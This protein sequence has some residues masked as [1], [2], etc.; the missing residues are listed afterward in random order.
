[1]PEIDVFLH[2]RRHLRR[3]A[4]QGGA[5]AASHQADTSPEIRADFQLVAAAAMQLHHALL[6]D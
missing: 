4:D 6:A 1:M 5:R 2:P 3:V